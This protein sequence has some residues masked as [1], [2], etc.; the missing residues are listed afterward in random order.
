M[1]AQYAA[2]SVGVG[3]VIV[4]RDSDDLLQC[5]LDAVGT[6]ND[7][8]MKNLARRERDAQPARGGGRGRAARRAQ[9]RGGCARETEARRG[10]PRVCGC[11][12]IMN[13]GPGAGTTPIR[14]PDIGTRIVL[15]KDDRGAWSRVGLRET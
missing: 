13:R 8:R 6:H 10:S 11:G 5:A 12:C 4:P 7:V 3:A 15:V 2:S 1:T 9:R 14:V